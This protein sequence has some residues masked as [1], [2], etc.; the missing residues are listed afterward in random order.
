M[1]LPNRLL[2]GRV[3]ELTFWEKNLPCLPERPLLPEPETPLTESKHTSVVVTSG[4]PWSA[5]FRKRDPEC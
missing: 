4:P 5:Q 2:S 3:N 1:L